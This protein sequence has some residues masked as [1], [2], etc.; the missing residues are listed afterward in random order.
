MKNIKKLIALGLALAMTMAT[1]AGCGT[2]EE[3]AAPEAPAAE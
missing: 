3:A 1:L 2:K